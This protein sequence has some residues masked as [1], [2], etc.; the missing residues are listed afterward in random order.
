MC[1][2][3]VLLRSVEGY[4]S[5]SLVVIKMAILRSDCFWQRFFT[6]AFST[7][8]S[9]SQGRLSYIPCGSSSPFASLKLS[10][11][12]LSQAEHLGWRLKVICKVSSSDQILHWVLISFSDYDATWRE[13]RT[14]VSSITESICRDYSWHHHKA[15]DLLWV[16][17]GLASCYNSSFLKFYHLWGIIFLFHSF[18][19]ILF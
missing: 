7:A 2:H 13:I 6:T 19:F 1:V 3:N 9:S 15:T 16:L 5:K 4:Q 14:G 12:R 18:R 10:S 17:V 8:S 11:W